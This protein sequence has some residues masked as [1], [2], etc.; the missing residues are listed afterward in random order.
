MERLR[1]RLP[2]ITMHREKKSPGEKNNL[3]LGNREGIC[4]NIGTAQKPEKT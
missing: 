3:S 4:A 1:E 2:K